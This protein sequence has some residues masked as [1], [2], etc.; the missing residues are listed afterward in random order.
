MSVRGKLLTGFIIVAL[1]LLVVGL[2]GFFGMMGA[3][4]LADKLVSDIEIQHLFS[5]YSEKVVASLDVL[6]EL[7]LEKDLQKKQE[8]Y[9]NL[10]SLRKEAE[11]IIEEIDKHL[12]GDPKWE[13]AKKLVSQRKKAVEDYVRAMKAYDAFKME[14]PNKVIEDILKIHIKHS[15]YIERL[16][17]F[18][19]GHT[20]EFKGVLDPTQCAFGKWLASYTPKNEKLKEYL[21]DIKQYH[22]NVHNGARE[23]VELVKSGDPKAKEKAREIFEKLVEPSAKKVFEI[24]KKIEDLAQQAIDTK[25]V[26]LEKLA[27]MK[28]VD[29]SLRGKINEILNGVVEMASKDAEEM[30][31]MTK[32][33]EVS[34]TIGI[35]IG[36]VVSVLI[37]WFMSDSISKRVRKLQEAVERLGDG[38]LTARVEIEGKDEIAQMG[39][40]LSSAMEN[41]RSSVKEIADSS[42]SLSDFSASLDDFTSRQADSL[43]GMAQAVEQITSMAES[44]SAAIEEL[45]S[46]VQEV[47]SSAQT[48]SSM[49]QD[50]TDSA[51]RMAASAGEGREALSKVIEVVRRVVDET[52]NTSSIVESV[53]KRAENIGQILETIES[54]AEQ[55]NLLALNAAIEAARAGEAGKGFA[56]VADEIRKLAEESRKATENIGKILFEIK[57]ESERASEATEGVVKSVEETSE[58]AQSV[59]EKFEEIDEKAKE[60]LSMSENV[61]ATAQEQGA[62]SEEM[63]SAMDNASRSVLEISEKIKTINEG[64]NELKDQSEDLSMRGRELREM[65]DRLASLVKKFKI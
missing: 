12:S 21:R 46:G 15:E 3:K 41:L 18:V 54:I 58:L 48:L 28:D 49:A 8:L 44:T 2:V 50:L 64:M 23:I 57:E 25:N 35:I 36:F 62:A 24:F 27:V 51:N 10:A 34:I 17:N 45:T 14:D 5:M 31:S 26:A 16:R 38:D 22:D 63:A 7:S 9:E 55:T 40:V 30:D 13:E 52:R 65:A 43:S 42:Q 37:G 39:K 1:V 4:K 61:A 29:S 11:E 53:A 33:S 47:A 60:V 56:V 20:K 32:R 6:T 19:L 59:M